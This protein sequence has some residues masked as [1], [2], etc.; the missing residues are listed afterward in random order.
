LYLRRYFDPM[1]DLSQ[2][3]TVFQ[4][5]AAALE[6]I[7]GVLD[8]EPA[9]AEPAEPVA[10]PRPAT[11]TTGGAVTF[12]SVSF[13][14]RPDRPVLTGL[15]LSIHPGQTVALVGEAGAGKSSVARPLARFWDPAAGRVTPDR[16]DLRPLPHTDLP[17]AGA[18]A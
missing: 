10:L 18:L 17:R 9:V 15:D 4:S 1:Q 3:Y 12:E 14:Y 11:G 7:S 16:L 13:A 2:F 6:K 5:A 8:T